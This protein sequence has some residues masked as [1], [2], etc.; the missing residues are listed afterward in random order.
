MFSCSS[1]TLS[2]YIQI[3]GII[4]SLTTSIIAI[5]ISIKTLKQ[6]SQMIEE[7]TRPYLAIYLNRANFQSPRSYLI[8]KNFGQ[9]GALVTYIACD[10][11]LSAYSYDEN[12]VPFNNLVG[13]FIAPGQSFVYCINSQKIGSDPKDLLFAIQYTANKN[14]YSDHFTVHLKLN[15]DILSVRTSPNGKELQTISYALQELVEKHL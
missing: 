14:H 6:S 1:L 10:Q 11:D 2:D 9:S 13:S 8:L 5:V 4:A 12:Y 7:S 3:L 15:H